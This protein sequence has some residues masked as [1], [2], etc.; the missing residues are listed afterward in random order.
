MLGL[1]LFGYALCFSLAYITLDTG[2]GALI[3]FGTVQLSLIALHRI[4]GNQIVA[5]E[6]F[7]VL[8]SLA[9]FIALMSPSSAQPNWFGVILMITSGLCWSGFT[10]LG[11]QTKNAIDA[12]KTGF[13]VASVI[14]LLPLVLLHLFG[15]SV[16]VLT[17]DGV[18][19]ALA[20]GVLASA[21]GYALW[22]AILSRIT[23][24]QASLMQL[25]VPAIALVLG[26][27]FVAEQITFVSMIA[28]GCILGG[29]ALV[30]WARSR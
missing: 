10:L 4:Q 18:M 12:T 20:S 27:L 17:I 8:L 23:L 7:G 3:L 9:G 11:K 5:V 22:Y 16:M 26:G 25:S 13:T 15:Q 30:H 14:M 2:T 21:L 1:T 24:L 29:I 28:T 6:W 19:L